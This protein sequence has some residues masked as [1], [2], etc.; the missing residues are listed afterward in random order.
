MAKILLLA[1]VVGFGLFLLDRK[2]PAYLWLSLTCAANLA[3][4]TSIVL[5]FYNTW[6]LNRFCFRRRSWLPCC[7]G[8]PSGT[9]LGLLVPARDNGWPGCTA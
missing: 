4:L 3:D 6:L 9:L 2:E 5:P 7:H 1:L 8:R